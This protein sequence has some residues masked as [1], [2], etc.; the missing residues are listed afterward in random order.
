MLWTV[1][2]IVLLLL[3]AR[4]TNKVVAKVPFQ[5]FALMRKMV[6]RGLDDPEVDDCALVSPTAAAL[7]SDSQPA[8]AHC[9]A[10]P[11]SRPAFPASI[12]SS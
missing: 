12:T 10:L 7:D 6:H 2:L 1:P 5:P 3:D 8:E 4:Y 11:C 9:C